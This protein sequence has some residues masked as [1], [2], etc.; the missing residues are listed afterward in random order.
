LAAAHLESRNRLISEAVLH[1]EVAHALMLRVTPTN[2]PSLTE[3]LMRSA[4]RAGLFGLPRTQN[5]S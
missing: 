5:K 1:P 3:T 4:A 2:L